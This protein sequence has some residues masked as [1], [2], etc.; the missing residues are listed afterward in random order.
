M[1]LES[2]NRAM[3][4]ATDEKQQ[5]ARREH[6]DVASSSPWLFL[7]LTRRATRRE[8]SGFSLCLLMLLSGFVEQGRS[9]SARDT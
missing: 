8:L 3:T 1:D 6:D 9:L 5:R 4:A 7:G 2:Q